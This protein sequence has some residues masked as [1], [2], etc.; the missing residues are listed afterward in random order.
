MVATKRGRS[1]I[2]ASAI[3]VN[4]GRRQQRPDRALRFALSRF[5]VEPIM[6]PLVAEDFPR[7]FV[8]LG[9]ARFLFRRHQFLA[10]T[11]RRDLIL[12]NSPEQNFLLARVGIEIPRMVSVHQRYRRGPI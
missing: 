12:A 4:N 5:P 1:A 3:A 10:N 2:S 8:V 11:N 6:L 9:R 7:V